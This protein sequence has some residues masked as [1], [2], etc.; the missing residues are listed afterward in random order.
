MKGPLRILAA[1]L[2]AVAAAGA[3]S[4]QEN[5]DAY[6]LDLSAGWEQ[7]S[8]VDGAKI[9]RVE[10]VYG[11]RSQGLLKVKRIRA[12]QGQTLEDVV[13]RDV[14]GSLKFQPGYVQ[15]R[16]ERFAGGNLAGY[17]VQFDFTLGG[18]PM[19]GRFYYL[20]GADG[21]VWVLQFTGDRTTLG[22]IRNVTDQMARSFRGR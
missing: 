8:F 1:V 19:L 3:A 20:Q 21:S 15:G 4:A 9:R 18:K 13:A 2:V 6:T 16:H 5:A 11:D 10:Y 17:L 7:A 12:E 22:E 14:E